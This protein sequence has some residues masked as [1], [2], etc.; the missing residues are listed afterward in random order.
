MGPIGAVSGAVRV[1]FGF[2]KGMMDAVR[3]HPLKRAG[4]ESERSAY[5]Q[6]AFK[7]FRRLESAMGEQSMITQ[8]DPPA[9]CYPPGNYRGR[10]I[11][12][13]KSEKGHH[14]HDM[15]N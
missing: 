3:R 1:L 15:E 4:L 14:G 2:R 13:A 11:L 6:K 5:C 8:P 7:P 10:E 12:P 9:T